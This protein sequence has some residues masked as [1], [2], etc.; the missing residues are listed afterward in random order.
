MTEQSLLEKLSIKNEKK[1]VLLIM[2]GVGGA[3]VQGKT[4]LEAAHIPNLDA[5]A[6]KSEVGFSIPILPGITPGSGPGHLGVFGYNPLDYEIGRGV[7][8][9]VGM[10]MALDNKSLAARCNFCTID[11]N[12]IITDRRAGRIPTEKN[13]EL[14]KK[15]K[16]KIKKID[17]VDVVIEPGKEHRFVVVFKGEGLNEP[18]SDA[19]PQK[20]GLNYLY[21][22]PLKL[23]SKK[24]AAIVNKF[25]DMVM[26]VLKN[27]LPA[28][29]ALLRGAAKS[30][31]IPSMEKLFK[32]KSAAIAVYPMYKGLASLVGMDLLEA[33]QTIE[34]EFAVL[35]KYYNDYDFF[36]IHI[37]KIDSYGEDGNFDAKVHIIEE[38]DKEI[39]NL[40]K[41]NLDVLCITGDHSTPALLKGHS[42]HPVP[43]L[44]NSP[45][46]RIS[47]VKG[48]NESECAKGNLGHIEA[49]YIMML[50][51][52]NA[53]KLNKYG[54]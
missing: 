20:E 37:K 45:F 9:A 40:L 21:S 11:K 1:I 32:L 52:A 8:E 51:L 43:L 24:S 28:N 3:P 31:D 6:A 19:D 53:L 34:D 44:I 35:K 50:L 39:P 38:V 48:F 7:L 17:D 26:D 14:C 27:D 12:K 47:N 49:R 13:I 18:I 15:L 23:E 10:G 4:E 41:L 16:E 36:F 22:V 54:A 30:P 29:A 25:L 42:W 2:D 33:G 46:V 5:L